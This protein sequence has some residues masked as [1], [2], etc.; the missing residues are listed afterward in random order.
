LIGGT[1]QGNSLVV[2]GR[3]ENRSLLLSRLPQ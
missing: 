3:H 2:G 1:P